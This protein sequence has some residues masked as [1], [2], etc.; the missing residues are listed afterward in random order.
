MY[1][2]S[3]HGMNNV[4][5]GKGKSDFEYSKEENIDDQEGWEHVYDKYLSLQLTHGELYSGY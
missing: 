1:A 2:D 4:D 3:L 5:Y